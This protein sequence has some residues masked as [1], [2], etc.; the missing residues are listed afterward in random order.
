MASKQS[1]HDAGF[2]LLELIVVLTLSALLATA[3]LVSRRSAQ[4]NL[5]TLALQLATE[6]NAA[7]ESA[8]ASD[9]PV[10]L[11]IDAAGRGYRAETRRG[12]VQMPGDVR[13]RYTPAD[14]LGHGGGQPNVAYFADGSS[15]GGRLRLDD[16]T[17]AVALRVDTLTG[18]VAVEG[19]GR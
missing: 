10:R 17:N 19:A 8:I 9:R 14:Q 1:D 13:I 15:T 3:A 18:A 2:S 4:P 7:R 16:G 6:L 11:W 12:S 5:R